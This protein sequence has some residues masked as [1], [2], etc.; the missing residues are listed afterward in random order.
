MRVLVE[1]ECQSPGQGLEDITRTRAELDKF[2]HERYQG[3]VVRAR[4]EKFCLGEQPTKRAMEEE[5][6]YAI[7]KEIHEIEQN[8]LIVTDKETIAHV[9]FEHYQNIFGNG[10]ASTDNE[11]LDKLVSLLPQLEKECKQE[12]ETPFTLDEV[13]KTVNALPR[14][15]TPGPD[16]IPAEFYQLQKDTLCPILLEIFQEAYKTKSLPP[17]FLRTHT[18]LIPK[19]E[20]KHKLLQVTG[21]RPITLCNVDYKIF[22]KLLT[23]RLQSLICGLV[24]EHQTCGIRGRAIQTNVHIARSV[25]ECVTNSSEQIAMVQVDLA[26]A[27]DRVSHHVLFK[28]LSHI[29]VGDILLQG[30]QMSYSNCSTRL[31]INNEVTASIPVRSSVRQGCPLSPLLFTLYLEPLCQSILRSEKLQGFTLCN[32]EVKVLAYAD[33]VAY[34]CKD[35]NSV[36]HAMELTHRFCEATGA[37]V[38]L[39][40]CRGF[41]HGAWATMPEQYEGIQWSC[42]PCDYLGV[43]LRHFRNSKSYWSGIATGLEKRAKHWSHKNLSIFARSTVCNI[44]LA[45]KLWYVL[46]VLHCAR[47]NIQKLHRVFSVLVWK[48][49]W[50]PMRRDNLFRRVSEGGLGL[51][52]LFIRQ[53]VSRF[54]F[55]RDQEH[56][57]L[58][59]VIQ[60]K[61]GCFLADFIVSSTG[62]QT[63]TLVGYLKEVVDAYHFLSVRFSRDYLTSVTRKKLTRDLVCDL[64]P[65]PVYRTMFGDGPDQDVLRRVKKMC[66]PPAAKTFF[67]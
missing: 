54:I 17:S 52:H 39:E 1:L 67:F 19:T 64:F 2:H 53:L 59:D 66:I 43:P 21:Y 37:S 61:L 33:D 18:I 8:S 11:Y 41:W 22:A 47:I 56:P 50:E 23:N 51:P 29:G 44:F 34:F 63:C 26:K 20:D 62:Y 16:G 9:F 31:V 5:K 49:S 4:A 38:N 65:M 25:L 14:R 10:P 48:S 35:K 32:T 6:R 46:Q 40:K 45:A 60:N 13:E 27:F 30:V 55:L 57:F 28:I 15:K 36:S 12:F 42:T 3:A 7:S 24:G 58:R